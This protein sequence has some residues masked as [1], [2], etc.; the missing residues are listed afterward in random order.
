[1]ARTLGV[2]AL[3]PAGQNARFCVKTTDQPKTPGATPYMLNL[4]TGGDL[5][6]VRRA[7]CRV[8]ASE[9]V[10]ASP[11]YYVQSR[12]ALAWLSPEI[13]ALL[14]PITRESAAVHDDEEED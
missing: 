9:P 13:V 4:T 7:W 1:M 12:G 8:Y 11:D 10:E 14:D 2:V 3:Q 5:R 6:G